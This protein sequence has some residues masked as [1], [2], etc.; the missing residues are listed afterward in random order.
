MLSLDCQGSKIG[1]HRVGPGQLFIQ[2]LKEC[3]HQIMVLSVKF[4]D[5]RDLSLIKLIAKVMDTLSGY[6]RAIPGTVGAF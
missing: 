2:S 6:F 4:Q 5:N 3:V 1:R